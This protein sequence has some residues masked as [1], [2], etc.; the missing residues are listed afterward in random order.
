MLEE[1]D[2]VGAH[3]MLSAGMTNLG[4]GQRYQLGIEQSAGCTRLG[5]FEYLG[6]RPKSSFAACFIRGHFV[7]RNGWI[8][9]A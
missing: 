9:L 8:Q 2:D 4:R 7:A 5:A 3:A 6:R 1:N